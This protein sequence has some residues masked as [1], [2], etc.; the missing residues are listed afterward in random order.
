[1]GRVIATRDTDVTLECWSRKIIELRL[2]HVCFLAISGQAL[3]L[4]NVCFRGV[5]GHPGFILEHLPT[6]PWLVPRPQQR[7]FTGFLKPLLPEAPWASICRAEAHP[8]CHSCVTAAIEAGRFCLNTRKCVSCIAADLRQ[9]VR[10]TRPFGVSSA[11]RAL[12][13][14]RRGCWFESSTAHHI[15]D[16]IRNLDIWS[17]E[18]S[19]RQLTTPDAGSC[20]S[21]A[22]PFYRPSSGPIARHREACFVYAADATRCDPCLPSA[23]SERTYASC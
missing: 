8:L 11:G 20:S 22:C 15:S 5:S 17:R 18:H 6:T 14:H 2:G 7:G 21:L 16:Y 3:A 1:M 19:G 4:T 12:C 13:S 10:S 23:G 9:L